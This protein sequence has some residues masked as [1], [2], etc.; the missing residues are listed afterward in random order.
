MH[1]S[2]D[3]LGGAAVFAWQESLVSFF[4]G[5]FS[6]PNHDAVLGMHRKS[7]RML[8]RSVPGSE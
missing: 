1:Y 3:L 4:C 2:H 8:A 5:E 7:T 6:Y